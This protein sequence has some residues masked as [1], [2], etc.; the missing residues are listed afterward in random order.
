MA[1][2]IDLWVVRGEDYVA[3]I[4][5]TDGY[6][7]AIAVTEPVEAAVRDEVGQTVLRFTSTTDPA[8]APHIVHNSQGFFQL[9]MPASRTWTVHPGMY[10]F[11]L[12]AAV[13][14][15]APPFTGQR[16]QVIQGTMTFSSPVSSYTQ[17]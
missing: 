5:W 15:S 2:Q 1:E 3:Q 8:N 12:W 11:D 7:E 14:D 6:G 16:Q 9:T 4:F 13:G 10:G 17:V